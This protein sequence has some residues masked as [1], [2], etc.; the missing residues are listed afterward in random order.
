MKKTENC[1][2]YME[3]YLA[4]ERNQRLPFKIT[5]HLI[6]CKDCR[7]KVRM[8]SEADKTCKKTSSEQTDIYNPTIQSI[9]KQLNLPLEETTVKP[10]SL[11]PWFIGGLAIF[12]AIIFAVLGRWG[13]SS[14]LGIY[15]YMTLAT[16]L[17]L[18]IAFFIFGHMDFFVKKFDTAE[19]GTGNQ[20]A[21]DSEQTET[22]AS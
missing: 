17:V 4:L 9:L 19:N 12:V 15:I 1:E 14:Q 2:I 7:S 11:A 10:L 22:S 5:W 21:I 8:L 16:I 18:Y 13:E 20:Q 6:T 3:E